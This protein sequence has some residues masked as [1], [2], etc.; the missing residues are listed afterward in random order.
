MAQVRY[1]VNAQGSPTRAGKRGRGRSNGRTRVVTW[2]VVAVD[3]QGRVPVLKGSMV[4]FLPDSTIF[5]GEA[6]ALLQVALATEGPIDVTADCLGVTRMWARG[7]GRIFREAWAEVQDQASRVKVTWINSHLSETQFTQKFQEPLWRRNVNE[8]A[9]E[10]CGKL[11]RRLYPASFA[12]RVRALDART[13]KW[14]AFLAERLLIL[15]TASSEDDNPCRFVPQAQRRATQPSQSQEPVLN[16][17]QRLKA[18]VAG[19]VNV[20]GHEWA[21]KA[22]STNNLQIE[23]RKCGLWVQQVYGP[24]VFN[25]I[26]RQPCAGLAGFAEAWA[27]HPSRHMVNIVVPQVWLQPEAV[28]SGGHPSARLAMQRMWGG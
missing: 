26:C 11:A 18:M 12:E 16:K 5:A 21:I 23:C 8:M 7:R 4:G 14:S 24:P 22:Q 19:E 6:H 15:T 13:R 10:A 20:L 17:A 25:R 9:D 28:C 3:V 2:S 27:V 1:Y